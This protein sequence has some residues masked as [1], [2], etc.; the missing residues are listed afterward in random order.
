MEIIVDNL[1]PTITKEYPDLCTCEKCISDIKALTLNKLPP[2]YVVNPS[3]EMFA[4][5]NEL[6]RDFQIEVI[7]KI[8]ESIN[9][10]HNNTKHHQEKKA[11]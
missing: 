2:M 8:V 6:D 1:L 10:V 5:A 11:L 3:G 9:T 4:R 7:Q